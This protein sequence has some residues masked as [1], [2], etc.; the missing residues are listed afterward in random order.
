M[1][2]VVPRECIHHS[3]HKY[4]IKYDTGLKHRPESIFIL[5]QKCY[6]QPD[7]SNPKQI[8]SMELLA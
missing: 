8:I 5:C 2:I 4:K 1:Q 6:E 3:D 7:F